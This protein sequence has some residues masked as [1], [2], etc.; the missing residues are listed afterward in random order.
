MI[1]FAL[2]CQRCPV[3]RSPAT[4][5]CQDIYWWSNPERRWRSEIRPL[6]TANGRVVPF[7]WILALPTPEQLGLFAAAGILLR[8]TRVGDNVTRELSVAA[9]SPHFASEAIPFRYGL[10][11]QYGT[12]RLVLTVTR[13]LNVN[14]GAIPPNVAVGQT[15]QLFAFVSGGVPPYFYA[16]G[17]RTGLNDTDIAAPLATPSVTTEYRVRVNDS[18]GQEVIGST[19]VFVGMGLTAH[20]YSAGNRCRRCVG[21]PGNRN[22]RNATLPLRVVTQRHARLFACP[23]SLRHADGDDDLSRY[24]ARLVSPKHHPA[25]LSHRHCSS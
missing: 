22:G 8:T 13:P 15:S 19:T 23:E 21:A 6:K 11:A 4:L 25:C 16:W 7:R 5:T 2:G 1:A 3:D 9:D 10:R 18:L 14:V 20:G 24:G 17:P 12:A